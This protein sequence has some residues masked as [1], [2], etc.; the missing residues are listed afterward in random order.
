MLRRG[1]PRCARPD[2]ANVLAAP[3][4]LPGGFGYADSTRRNLFA[5]GFHELRVCPVVLRASA[6]YPLAAAIGHI[7]IMPQHSWQ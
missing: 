4:R 2:L 3:L 6:G 1:V 5:D 7:L